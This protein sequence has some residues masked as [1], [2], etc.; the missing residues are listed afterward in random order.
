MHL[1]VPIGT[2]ESSVC[3]QGEPGQ[4]GEIGLPGPEGPKVRS[5]S[6]L[7]TTRCCSCN[8]NICVPGLL[9]NP[10]DKLKVLGW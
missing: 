6:S 4:L 10:V 2:N 7:W 9:D 8:D 5:P 3:L 1:K